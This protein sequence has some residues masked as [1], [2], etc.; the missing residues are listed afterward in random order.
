M[1]SFLDV[2]LALKYVEVC[3]KHDRFTEC[4]RV[5]NRFKQPSALLYKAKCFFKRYRGAL[6]TYEHE[7]QQNVQ[8]Y[9]SILKDAK[10]TVSLLGTALD[11]RSIDYEGKQ[12]LDI[13]MMDVIR[14]LNEL[15]K[16][17]HPHCMLCLQTDVSLQKSHVYP[18]SLLKLIADTTEERE[19]G[20]VFTM[21]NALSP[22]WHYHYSSPKDV[23]FF[24][25]C[26]KCED[27]VNK[28]GENDFFQNFFSQLYDSNGPCQLM[29]DTTVAYGPWLYNFCIG[30]VFR[31][32][33]ATTGIPEVV[34]KYEIYDLFL[35]CRKFLLSSE[36]LNEDALPS[37]YFFV[38][39]IE[40][41]QQYEHCCIQEA[42]TSPGYC[43]IQT[44]DLSEGHHTRPL[45]GHYILVHCGIINVLI[46][47]SPANEALLPCNWKIN[48][49]AGEYTVPAEIN[50]DK[51]I[52][53]GVWTA[54]EEISKSFYDHI[55]K[56]LF[57]KKDKPPREI[58]SQSSEGVE[59]QHIKH[60]TWNLP[61]SYLDSPKSNTVISMLPAGFEIDCIS[62]EVVLPQGYSLL[63]HSTFV[64]ATT[65]EANITLLIGIKENAKSIDLDKLV[66][67]V[68]LCRLASIGAFFVGYSISFDKDIYQYS[69]LC[70]T[71]L[72]HASDEIQRAE[73]DA[74][75]FIINSLPNALREKGFV[76]LK[77]LMYNH[78]HK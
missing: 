11:K 20:K 13:A 17:T 54:F 8:N 51:Y 55:T 58:K 21:A 34:N 39:S 63:L 67:F 14:G 59:Y 28:G 66:P 26:S 15:Y 48:P 45:K 9:L 10:A 30:L 40:V 78:I 38:N 70:E 71:D 42:L 50:K 61:E 23:R 64:S 62:S 1:I 49:Q 72:V 4:L 35:N 29:E 46:K 75:S 31:C 22:K 52:P 19:G 69:S 73:K 3:Y 47:F 32:I 6:S 25:L 74:K 33:A 56:S 68:V 27:V 12:Q 16:V 2:D 60:S 76:N 77:S 7:K 36:K 44:T 65:D 24:M 37:V 43:T 41:P 57:R 18:R 53:E 5:A